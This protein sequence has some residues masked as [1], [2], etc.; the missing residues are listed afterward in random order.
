MCFSPIFHNIFPY[1][2]VINFL[3]NNNEIFFRSLRGNF[4]ATFF[5]PQFFFVHMAVDD[6]HLQEGN[7]H[8]FFHTVVPLGMRKLRNFWHFLLR[9]AFSTSISNF[10]LIFLTFPAIDHTRPMKPHTNNL[11]EFSFCSRSQ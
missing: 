6:G 4:L 2:F 10:L 11:F 5:S 1:T 3:K 8:I 7:Y 9:Q